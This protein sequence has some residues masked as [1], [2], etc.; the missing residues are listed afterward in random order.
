VRELENVVERIVVLVRGNEV[1]LDDL[2]PFLRQERAGPQALEIELPP[3]GV[4][5][6]AIEKE[7]IT[8]ALERSGWNQTR[9]ARYLDISRKTLIYRMERH[10]ITKPH[11]TVELAD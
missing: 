2:P 9:A 1:T 4:S 6:E 5:L 8:K 10:G 7:L 11:D 3:Q